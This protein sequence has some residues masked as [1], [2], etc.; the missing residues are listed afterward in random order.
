MWST[1]CTR[2]SSC[3]K[4]REMVV[5]RGGGLDLSSSSYIIIRMKR[6]ARDSQAVAD[7]G[8][9]SPMTHTTP[10]RSL[11]QQQQQQKGNWTLM[12]SRG[13]SSFLSFFLS[14]FFFVLRWPLSR[15]CA[16]VKRGQNSSRA[17][18]DGL[19]SLA[20]QPKPIDFLLLSTNVQS[21]CNFLF[22]YIKLRIYAASSCVM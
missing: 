16:D 22:T 2:D 7:E 17:P 6:D 5:G 10:R 21:Q 11:S 20:E 14:L 3:I 18:V 15:C 4:G 1:D 19:L 9:L 12:K 8:D 13:L